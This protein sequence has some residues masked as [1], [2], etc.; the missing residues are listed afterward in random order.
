MAS[1]GSTYLNFALWAVA[2]IPGWIVVRQIGVTLGDRKVERESVA[3][4]ALVGT[5]VSAE[6]KV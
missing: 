4:P 5:G 3:L 6:V 1:V 2:L